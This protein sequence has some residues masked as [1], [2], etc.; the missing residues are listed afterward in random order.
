YVLLW[1]GDI[2][3]YYGVVG[4]LLFVFRNVAPR[5]MVVA[6]AVIMILQTAVTVAEWSD[7]R[8][9]VAIATA[10]QDARSAGKVLTEAQNA[11]LDTLATTN[12][13]FKPSRDELEKTVSRMRQ[14]YLGAFGVVAPESWHFET[15]FFYQHGLLESLGM[16]L[17]GMALLKYGVLTGAASR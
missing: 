16:M 15:T 5:K 9:T 8:E 1:S 12:E 6:S 2:L 14:S 7:Y 10:A 17:L 11:A 3:Y 13:Q 4:L